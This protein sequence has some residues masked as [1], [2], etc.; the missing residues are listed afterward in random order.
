MIDLGNRAGVPVF[1]CR[2]ADDF[3]WWRV[4]ALNGLAKGHLPKRTEMTE[5]EW[6]TFLYRIRGYEPPESLF[7]G[8][9]VEV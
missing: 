4:V 9:E 2:Y 3:S 1:A 5:R 8:L 7:D 6:V